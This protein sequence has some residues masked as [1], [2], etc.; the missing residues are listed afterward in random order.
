MSTTMEQGPRD[1]AVV[2]F[3]ARVHAALDALSDAAMWSMTPGELRAVL[4]ELARA[5]ARLHELRLRALV[6]ADS[7]DI[8]AESAATS[9]AAWVAHRTRQVRS[10]AHA[11]LQLAHELDTTDPTTR[12]ALAD[13]RLDV[14]QARVVVRAV[15]A[16]P[17]SVEAH[18]RELAEKHLVDAAGEHDAKALAILG[19]RVFE[20]IDPEAADL[21]EGRRLQAEEEAAAR[22]TYLQLADNGDGTHTGR[23]RMSALHA[24]MLRKALQAITSPRRTAVEDAPGARLTGPE[25]MG[26]AF[27]RLLERLPAEGLPRSGGMSATV[28]VLLDYDKLLSGLGAARLDTGGRISAGLARRMVCESGVVPVVYQRVLGGRSVVLD[29]GRR[30]RFHSEAQ[31][32]ALTVRDGGCSAEG[33]D[34]P[35]AWTEAHHDEVAWHEGGGTSVERGRLLCPHHH[36]RAHDPAYRMTRL[37]T[38]GVGFHRRT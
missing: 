8:A 24:A 15:S 14:A 3:S 13:G 26:H 36:R 9:T 31:R 2:R 38:G 28:V 22:A 23:F 21:E 12:Q 5:E 27:G 34:R 33:C 25:V 11:E 4:P 32:I 19:R 18:E 29:V 35:P 37:P 16:L 30:R 20:V 6:A 1:H 17:M 10:T 7:A